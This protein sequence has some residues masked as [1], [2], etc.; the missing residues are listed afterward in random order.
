MPGPA[1]AT[2]CLLAVLNGAIGLVVAAPGTVILL[3]VAVLDFLVLNRVL[4]S[5]TAT[6]RADAGLA[7]VA[8]EI[9]EDPTGER[10]GRPDPRVAHDEAE[11]RRP[12]PREA[13]A[14][15]ATGTLVVAPLVEPEAVWDAPEGNGAHSKTQPDRNGVSTE[16]QAEPE[17]TATGPDTRAHPDE[18]GAGAQAHREPDR[19][20]PETVAAPDG[21]GAGTA[22]GAELD[23]HGSRN[24]VEA[25]RDGHDAG[26][27]VELGQSGNGTSDHGPGAVAGA[28]M[29][30]AVAPRPAD[31]QAPAPSLLER[32]RPAVAAV[33][34]AAAAGWI[35]YA[36][37]G[38]MLIPA[39]LVLGL[40]IPLATDLDRQQAMRIAGAVAVAVA[41][42]DYVSWR[43]AV[44]N[45][46]GWWIAV[47]LL[48]AEVF[49]A[50]HV[51]GFQF[52]TWPWPSKPLD[53]REDPTLYPIFIAVPTVDEGIEILTPTLQACITARRKYL[54]ANPHGQVTIV[55]CNDGRVARAP[56][57]AKVEVLARSLGVRCVTR[58]TGGGA[59]AGNIEYTRKAMC[60]T[61][62]ALLVIFD[63]DQVPAP[64]FLLKTVPPFADPKIGWVQ[65][66]QYYANLNNPVA[67]WAD[68]QQSMFYNVLCPGKSAHNGA[69][70]CGTNVVLRAAALDEIGGLPQDSVTEDFAAS[71]ALHPRWRSVYLTEVLAT[72][73]GPLDMP[74][75]L[76]QQ[77][78]WALGTLGVFRSHWR[79][80][81]LPRRH[82]LKIEQRAQYFLA[83]THY[84][85][86][87]R[88]FIYMATPALF[89]IT[90]TPAVRSATLTQ[91]LW[92]FLPYA[93]L[94]AGALWYSARGLTG[95]RGIVVGFGSFP[96]LVGSLTSVLL[97]RKAVF[98]VTSKL[99]R[100][101]RSISY[102]RVH[103]ALTLLCISSLI[104]ASRVKGLQRTSL[105][106]SVLW[107]VY[108]LVLLS[109]YFWL[110]I[111]D[112]RF[113]AA[114][115]HS[116]PSNEVAEK[117]DYPSKLPQRPLGLAPIR[118]LGLAAAIACPVLLGGRLG[119]LPAFQSH[120]PVRFV[121]DRQPSPYVGLTM[122]APLLGDRS[123]LQH[124]LGTRLTIVG[125]TQDITDRFDRGWAD[126]LSG[127][128]ARPWITLEFG[129]F[130]AGG[131]APLDASLPAIVNGVHDGDLH[132]WASAIRDFEKPVYLTVLLH[133]DKN[134]SVSSGVAHGGIPEDV[135]QAWSHIQS[136]FRAAGATNVGWVWAPADP[137]HDQAFA[138]Q[139][140]TIDAVLQ[141]F[142]NYPG[143]PWGDPNAVLGE[144][145]ARYP[146][147]A[148]FV[149][150]SVDG[151]AAEKAA[152]IADLAQAIQH[153]PSVYAFL[154]HEGGPSLELKPSEVK[155]WSFESDA[156]SLTA[157]RRLV[158]NVES[159]QP[160]PEVAAA[161]PSGAGAPAPVAVGPRPGAAASTRAAGAPAVVATCGAP[162][163]P[164]AAASKPYVAGHTYQGFFVATWVNGHPV[165]SSGFVL[166][167]TPQL[168]DA[169]CIGNAH[170]RFACLL[171]RWASAQHGTHAAAPAGS[172]R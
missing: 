38:P 89:I 107:V 115:H 54:A 123:S 30:S 124:D 43:L 94:S 166:D 136:V 112:R 109:S 52:T 139:R 126:Q 20:G 129:E 108:S 46:S 66:G 149:E 69:F 21:N 36:H 78:R 133:A 153:R 141:S 27:Q 87:L 82:G 25:E 130:G 80:V 84:M 127:A 81:L 50:V 79:D 59:K 5:P 44:T 3:L 110:A 117:L 58:T 16:V 19:T 77:G 55:V 39:V 24:P 151:P 104:W 29:S 100:R 63:A 97:R 116:E 138:P 73:L 40:A 88:D 155:Q 144:L 8:G 101:A 51:L 128:G 92:H 26:T 12:S 49:G 137:A 150:A 47:P 162:D 83:C 62:D 111:Q 145:E 74:S 158:A 45:W 147:M 53:P 146:G 114:A 164:C 113:H 170:Q 86:G 10:W 90:R 98:A 140:S 23:A 106:I 22:A 31:D 1:W 4:R 9:V 57:W 13:T 15:Q 165:D 95:L 11:R 118:N 171:A 163:E 156:A 172:R 125:R 161:P 105:F 93:L 70:I 160:P 68:D 135:P 102:L 91:Y 167:G 6:R 64:D 71:I 56:G 142:I 154:Y 18:N 67:R 134:W 72:G 119:S 60:I 152:W 169:H 33:T 17:G 85:C 75:Y 42:V 143:T 7:A 2:I 76:K 48:W 168:D 132:R 99:R 37:P 120:H 159:R 14:R 121:V 148:L 65:T 103:I 96:V 122:P 28:G 131:Q 32:L 61:G 34:V 157:M 35:A 41:S